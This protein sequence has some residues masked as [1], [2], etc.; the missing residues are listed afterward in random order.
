MASGELSKE[1]Q[2]VLAVGELDLSLPLDEIRALADRH[3]PKVRGK[4]VYPGTSEER[5]VPSVDNGIQYEVPVTVLRPE[6]DGWKNVMVYFHGGGFVR[7]SRKSHM[8]IC[9]LI[10]Q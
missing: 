7:G 6:G 1:S 5:N 4:F 3:D 9:E 10:S 8:A 2:A